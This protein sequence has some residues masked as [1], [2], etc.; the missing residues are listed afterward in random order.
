MQPAPAPDGSA[1]L[2]PAE[3]GVELRLSKA[4]VYRLINEG[5]L[6]VVY[7]GTDTAGKTKGRAARIRRADIEAFIAASSQ[8]AS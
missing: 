5:R 2:R 8:R 1:L 7:I 3:A 6:P 4:T